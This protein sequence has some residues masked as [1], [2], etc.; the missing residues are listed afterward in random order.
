MEFEEYPKI[1]SGLKE[2]KKAKVEET[3]PITAQ[4]FF[5]LLG[6]NETYS[7]TRINSRA[8]SVHN[9]YI[10]DLPMRINYV[11]EP[12]LLADNIIVII[13]GRNLDNFFSESNL[14]LLSD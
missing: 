14:V 13:T 8:S 1:G 2:L 9:T 5:L 6:T 4:Y 10:N 11:S 7:S 12:I 3:S